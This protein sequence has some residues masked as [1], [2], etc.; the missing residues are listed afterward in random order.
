MSFIKVRGL[1]RRASGKA[2]LKDVSLDV[3]EGDVL[4]IIGPSGAGKTSLLRCI[5]MLDRPD[6]G[7]IT[8]DGKD[9]WAGDRLA[10]QRSMAMVFQK[11]QPFSMSVYDNIAYGLR[12]RHVSRENIDRAVTDA[13]ELLDMAGKERQ[14]AKSLSG[15]EAQRLAFARAYVL[16][17]KLLLLDEPTAN[18]DPA[19]ASIM[20]RAI[21]DINKRYGT[22]VILVTHNMHQAR[23]LASHTAFMMDGQ[24]V[25]LKPTA[26][27]FSAA[28]DPQ[29]QEFLKGDMVC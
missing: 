20:E 14:Y 10:T 17:P 23:R 29:T 11:P 26:E 8:F 21:R 4:G 27:L 15:G 1:C 9:L 16:K 7:S 19:N 13:L 18:L 5:D 28:S 25:E 24:L 12:L 6:A 3:D 22:T 2:I